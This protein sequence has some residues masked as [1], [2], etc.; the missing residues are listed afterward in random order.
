ME[1]NS[2]AT[3]NR[4]EEVTYGGDKATEKWI[5]H[6]MSAKPCVILVAGAN[7]ANRKWFNNEIRKAWNKDIRVVSVNIHNLLDLDANQSSKGKNPL[8]NIIV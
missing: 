7:T 3:S 5:D 4:W 8:E 6:N 2:G 1:D